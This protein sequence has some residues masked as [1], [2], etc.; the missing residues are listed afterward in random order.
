MAS[1]RRQTTNSVEFIPYSCQNIGQEDIEAV[2]RVLASDHLTQ[3]PCVPAFEDAFVRRHQSAHGIAVSNATA[4]LHIA[5]LAVGVG[6]GSK[7]WT[8]P[9]SFVAS[10]NCALHCGAEVDFVDI[11]PL[12]RNISVEELRIKLDKAKSLNALPQVVVSVDFAGFPAD[13]REIR[14]LADKYKFHIVQDASHSTGASYL[15]RPVS[16]QFS[17]AAVFSFHAVKIITTG[18]GGMIVTNDESIANNV[19]LLRTHGITK[20]P[21]RMQRKSEEPWYYEQTL[22]GYNYRMTE[23]QA[24]LGFSQLKRLEQFR[25]Q[26]KILADRYDDLLSELPLILPP[27]SP[28]RESA[29]HLY[30][31]EIDEQRSKTRRADVFKHLREQN[32]GV[33]VHYIPIHTQPFYRKLGFRFG[34]YPASERY[35]ERAISVPLFPALTISQQERVVD[36]L[37]IALKA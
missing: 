34:D 17:D 22:L 3:G 24:A 5:L 19:R 6:R 11:D 35:Y 26:R 33:N 30:V 18:E 9:N 28:D 2:S 13:L 14:E 16:S 32:I 31:V 37:R 20:D 10:A 4:G 8:T 21:E 27:R 36:A 12:T 15:G 7:V 29:W 25:A 23:L 1:I